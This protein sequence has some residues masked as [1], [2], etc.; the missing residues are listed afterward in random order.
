MVTDTIRTKARDKHVSKLA[1]LIE[2]K[3]KSQ[4]LKTWLK[5]HLSAEQDMLQVMQIHQ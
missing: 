4:A 5:H 1:A 2:K 3:Q